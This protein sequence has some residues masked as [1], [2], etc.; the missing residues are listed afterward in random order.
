M[1]R[2]ISQIWLLGSLLGFITLLIHRYY[3]DGFH[4]F[5]RSL[6]TICLIALVFGPLALAFPL[7]MMVVGKDKSDDPYQQLLRR[8]SGDK[9]LAE[10]LISYERN[11]SPKA[12]RRKLIRD[13]LDRWYRDSM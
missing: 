4:N 3:H 2:P 6:F 5:K 7:F 12:G 11:F 8:V 9:R 1:N 13:A 10:R